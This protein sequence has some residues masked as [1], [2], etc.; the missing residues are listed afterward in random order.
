MKPFNLEEFKKNPS[1]KIITRDGRSVQ[2]LC[3]NARRSYPIVALIE[4]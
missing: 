3:T 4:D 1:R 2:I